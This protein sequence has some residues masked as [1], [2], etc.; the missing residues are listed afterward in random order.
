MPEHDGKDQ[1]S[2]SEEI[3]LFWGLMLWGRLTGSESLHQIGA[4]LLA[5][6]AR[7]AREYFLPRRGNDHYPEDIVS[8]H[9]LGIFFM[10]KIEYTTWFCREPKCINGIQMIPLSPALQLIR[11]SDFCL[12][13]WEDKL[14]DIS[15]PAD[16]SWIDVLL[17]GNVAFHDSDLAYRELSARAP[18]SFDDGLTKV[19]ALYW[20]ATAPGGN[21]SLRR[22]QPEASLRGARSAAASV[23]LFGDESGL[24]IPNS[25]LNSAPTAAPNSSTSRAATPATP[26]LLLPV[27]TTMPDETA[28]EP[29]SSHVVMPG[30]SSVSGP[31]ATNK[32]WNNWVVDFL[33]G[34]REQGYEMPIY[35]QPYVIKWGHRTTRD[36]EPELWIAY[37]S[38]Q[39]RGSHSGY[40]G[41]NINPFDRQI[42][43]GVADDTVLGYTI[44]EEYL[45]GIHV[46]MS[47]P[48]DARR[49]VTFPIFAGAAYVSAHFEDFKP[50]LNIR[51][52][53]D[54]WRYRLRAVEKVWNGAWRVETADYSE[55]RVYVLDANLQFISDFDF[56]STGE[57]SQALNGWVRIAR[58]NSPADIEVLDRHA[59]AIAVGFD[60][61]LDPGGVW[62]YVFQKAASS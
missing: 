9:V 49:R 35:P 59:Q 44:V 53:R 39:R 45:A 54:A 27:A 61:E 28:F 14:I 8:N 41:V 40:S 3:N 34:Q 52:G 37:P 38:P 46:R 22:L 16:E 29:S 58:V 33:P 25:L 13:E 57:G 12:Q 15:R 11:D 5:V 51:A 2:V 10:N 50:R 30:R 7:T 4:T 56:S 31:K 55:Y 47:D 20:T 48:D 18:E 17:A 24:A 60:I 23:N 21:M 36:T 6:S 19:W 43:I 32:F 62:R 42:C 26:S 1:E